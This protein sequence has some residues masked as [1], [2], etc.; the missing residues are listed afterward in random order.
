MTLKT[1]VLNER[2]VA[3]LADVIPDIVVYLHVLFVALL[4]SVGFIADVALEFP[5]TP[6]LDHMILQLEHCHKSHGAH[7]TKNVLQLHVDL[8]Y[9]PRPLVA[10]G[11]CG[12][13]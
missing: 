6:V 11:K 9:V 7:I 4:S 3:I 5:F 1:T 13:T 10:H 8:G 2:A 12:R